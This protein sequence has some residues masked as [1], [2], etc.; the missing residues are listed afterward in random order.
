MEDQ[1]E[2]EENISEHYNTFIQ[3]ALRKIKPKYRE[4]IV[5]YYFEEKSYEEIATI[6][7]LSTNSVGTK[8]RRAKQQLKK[9]L[10]NLAPE[11]AVLFIVLFSLLLIGRGRAL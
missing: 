1:K 6:L 5:L 10:E 8:I 11:L 3:V 9:I 2:Q 7:G 4:V